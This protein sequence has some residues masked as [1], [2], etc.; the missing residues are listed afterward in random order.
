MTMKAATS[1]CLAWVLAASQVLGEGMPPAAD[2]AALE[3]A[4]A[5]LPAA[6]PVPA[7]PPAVRV[8]D[9]DFSDDFPAPNRINRM[10]SRM[11]TAGKVTHPLPPPLPA[12]A[13]VAAPAR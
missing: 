11:K 12:H 8:V 6:V 9:L 5:S 7:P 4:P 2:G 1:F 10:R 13:P 3:P